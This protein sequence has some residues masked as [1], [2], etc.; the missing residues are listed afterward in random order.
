MPHWALA[1]VCYIFLL[2]FSLKHGMAPLVLDHGEAVGMECVFHDCQRILI[3][4]SPYLE[5]RL[6]YI[7]LLMRLKKK[8]IGCMG[9]EVHLSL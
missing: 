4:H 2:N 7:C 9:V 1:L 6:V 8:V 5:C 3:L